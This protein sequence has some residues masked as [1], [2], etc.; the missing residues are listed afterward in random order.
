MAEYARLVKKAYLAAQS[1]PDY[2][3][4]RTKKIN[5]FMEDNLE[6]GIKQNA[7]NVS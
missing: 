7:E 1:L 6:Q 5:N 2:L 3:K 4:E